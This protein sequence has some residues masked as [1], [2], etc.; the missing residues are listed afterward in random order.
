MTVWHRCE[1]NSL[2]FPAAFQERDAAGYPA[3]VATCK[4]YLAYSLE[5]NGKDSA[6]RHNFNAIV[7]QQD[8]VESYE[9]AFQYC[10]Q[11]GL[12]YQ[13][14][15]A[16]MTEAF[17]LNWPPRVQVMC[18][19]NSLNGIPTCADSQTLTKLRNT[20]GFDGLVVSDQGQTPQ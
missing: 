17:F 19:Y 7:S 8:L 20:W 9:P 16:L 6:T 10:V 11:K 18:S 15:G 12:P 2:A 13:V 5:G 14:R 1:L 4:H 3:V